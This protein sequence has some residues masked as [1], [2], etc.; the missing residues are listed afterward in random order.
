[1]PVTILVHRNEASGVS[2]EDTFTPLIF[3]A[4]RIVLGRGSSCDVRLPDPSVSS[5]HASIRVRDNQYVIVDESSSNGTRLNGEKLSPQAPRGLRSGDCLQL[6]RIKLTVRLGAAPLSNPDATREVALGLVA[7]ILQQEQIPPIHMEVAQGAEAGQKLTLIV[8]N[9]YTLG[10]DPR[11]SLRLTERN[12]PPIAIELTLERGRVKITRCDE[13]GEM[14]LG[15]RMLVMNEPTFWF[16]KATLRLGSTLLVLHDPIARALE[17]SSLG[18]DEKIQ[19][20]PIAEE[21]QKQD[22]SSH[23]VSQEPK[24]ES[25]HEST[26]QEPVIAPQK[27]AYDRRSSWRGATLAFEIVALVLGLV[28]LIAS[29]FGLYLLLRK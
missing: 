18:E 26:T 8:N 14:Y 28:V 19:A 29:I 6:G 24:S 9:T 7:R 16:D 11:C 12:V 10:R 27:P 13:R 25:N 23:E 20:N 5:R 2:T 22:Q 15:E 3:D 4:P 21:P 1:M 17:Q